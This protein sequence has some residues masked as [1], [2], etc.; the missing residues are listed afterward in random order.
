MLMQF[1]ERPLKPLASSKTNFLGIIACQCRSFQA[2]GPN[3]WDTQR[4]KSMKAALVQDKEYT[5]MQA[6]RVGGWWMQEMV[7]ARQ[8]GTW[9]ENP[10]KK[11]KPQ[12]QPCIPKQ[13]AN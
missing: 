12:H 3:K 5:S 13:P 11:C 1:F 9:T 2:C 10:K 7:R 6:A 4:S 8:G